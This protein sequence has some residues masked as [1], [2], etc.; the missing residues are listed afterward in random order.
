M[1]GPPWPATM[2]GLPVHTPQTPASP[3]L[4]R[5]DTLARVRGEVGELKNVMVDNIEKVR[6]GWV[7]RRTTKN[8]LPAA[9]LPWGLCLAVRLPAA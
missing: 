5:A 4:C 9:C 7:G 1:Q 6:W 2:P 8:T 3:V